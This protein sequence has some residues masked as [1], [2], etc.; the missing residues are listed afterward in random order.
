MAI[1]TDYKRIEW[2][3]KQVVAL[4]ARV[5]ALEQWQ[6]QHSSN[7]VVESNTALDQARLQTY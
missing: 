6:S 7:H 4:Q 2:L 3:V 1:M 5:T